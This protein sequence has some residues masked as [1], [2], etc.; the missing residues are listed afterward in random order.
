MFDDSA[1]AEKQ[2]G[3]QVMRATW[4]GMPSHPSKGQ[5]A[6]GYQQIDFRD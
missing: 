4:E 5:V 6:I 2:P 3:L 1:C